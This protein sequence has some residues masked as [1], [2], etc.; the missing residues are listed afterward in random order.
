MEQC[1]KQCLYTLHILEDTPIKNYVEELN[2]IIY[3]FEK[4]QYEFDGEDHTLILFIIFFFVYFT[5]Y[6]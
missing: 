4:Y 6:I 2:I 5:A 1:L 3:R